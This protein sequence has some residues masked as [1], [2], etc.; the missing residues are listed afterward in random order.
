MK[1]I[2]NVKGNNTETEPT[3]ALVDDED[4]EGEE[5]G[6]GSG[7]A[8]TSKKNYMKRWTVRTVAQKIH[9]PQFEQL[10]AKY[11]VE[12]A[13]VLQATNPATND[14]M[15]SLTAEQV[16]HCRELAVKFNKG[17]VPQDVQVRCAPVRRIGFP[18]V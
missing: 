8:K 9:R 7:S 3:N 11:Q 14:L 15:G 4:D 16:N 10:L 1:A 2:R 17:E 12:F 6:T 13:D 18:Q 5:L